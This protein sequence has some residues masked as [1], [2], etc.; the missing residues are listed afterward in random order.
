VKLVL[1][2]W[3]DIT[4]HD[5]WHKLSALEQFITDDDGTLVNQIGFLYEQD[6]NQIVLVD[7]YFED[8]SLYGGIHK[9]PRGCIV[10]ISELK[11]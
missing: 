3:K 9:I 4:S 10:S 11:T 1:V 8:L 5:G 6:E 2:K 7:S